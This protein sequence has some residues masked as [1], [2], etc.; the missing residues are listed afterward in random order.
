[1]VAVNPYE[2]MVSSLDTDEFDELCAAAA[3]RSCAQLR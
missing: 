1:M 3:A 2:G